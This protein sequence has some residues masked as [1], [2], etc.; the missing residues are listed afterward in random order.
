MNAS[1]E[2]EGHLTIKHFDGVMMVE[3]R[4]KYGSDESEKNFEG[5]TRWLDPL[6]KCATYLRIEGEAT[7]SMRDRTPNE[8]VDLQGWLA[9]MKDLDRF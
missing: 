4:G 2:Y 5:P 1:Y 3:L 9:E 6:I 8:Y 7:V